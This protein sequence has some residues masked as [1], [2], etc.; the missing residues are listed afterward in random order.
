[1]AFMQYLKM[2][3]VSLPLP[4][5]YDL[6]LTDVEADSGGH[7]V[8]DTQSFQVCINCYLAIGTCK[9]FMFG[10]VSTTKLN[11]F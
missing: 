9:V 11:L 10:T 6:N 3:G 4:D 2:E 5:S 8:M 1:M 7:A